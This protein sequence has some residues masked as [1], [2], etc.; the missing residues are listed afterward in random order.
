MIT[1]D[2]DLILPI[3]EISYAGRTI[4]TW[5][6]KTQKFFGFSI[7]NYRDQPNLC[8]KLHPL[9]Q[10]GY[11]T[12]N[13]VGI[14]DYEEAAKVSSLYIT[15]LFSRDFWWEKDENFDIP[16]EY[17]KMLEEQTGEKRPEQEQQDKPSRK[18]HLKLVE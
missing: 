11:V 15:D 10:W 14:S 4:L 3:E 2:D 17:W 16:E 12:Y 13:G 5:Y 9:T 7:F 1:K 6:N 18:A 8:S